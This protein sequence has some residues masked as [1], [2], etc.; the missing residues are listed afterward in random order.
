MRSGQITL[1]MFYLQLVLLTAFL[2]LQLAG[3]ARSMPTEYYLLES[4]AKPVQTDS[5]PEKTLRVARVAVPEY[6]DRSGIVSRIDGQSR[7][8]VAQFHIWAEPLSQGVRRVVR[9]ALAPLLFASGI[10]VQRTED[11]GGDLVLFLDVE[12][13]DGAIG[14][15]ARTELRWTLKN[16]RDVV[17][18]QGSH[19]EDEPVQGKEYADLVRAQ[20]ILISRFAVRFAGLLPSLDS[21][22]R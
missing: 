17:L 14:G 11:G 6:L 18:G 21:N 1:E 16:R 19:A 4:S 22:S 20:S 8:V 2:L 15:K 13:F 7:L 10:N 9:E 5:L 12:R 3:C